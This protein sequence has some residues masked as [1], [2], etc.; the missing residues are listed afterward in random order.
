MKGRQVILLNPAGL[1]AELLL[2]EIHKRSDLVA[3]GFFTLDWRH[4]DFVRNRLPLPATMAEIVLQLEGTE[5]E[6]VCALKLRATKQKWNIAAVIPWDDCSVR[7]G[8]RISDAFHLPWIS[9]EVAERF[10]NKYLLKRYLRDHT[11]LRLN[12]FENCRDAQQALE[13]QRTL[14]TWPVILKPVDAGG[15]WNVWK[16]S[17]E[18]EITRF[19]NRI[20]SDFND[21][22]K[23]PNREVL[24]EEHV[25][26]PE[27]CINGL[28][29][30]SGQVLVTDIFDYDQRTLHGGSNVHYHHDYIDPRSSHARPLVEYATAVI[31]AGGLRNSPF[32]LE[33]RQGAEGPVLMEVATRFAGHMAALVHEAIVPDL[34][35]QALKGYL[36]EL[37]LSQPVQTVSS[38][39]EIFA[40]VVEGIAE[41]EGILEA[42]EGLHEVERL[43]SFRGFSKAPSLGSRVSKT[44]NQDGRPYVGFLAHPDHARLQ[45]DKRK[46][47]QLLRLTIRK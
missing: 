26:G 39:T 47:R 35:A 46:M 22:D 17:T 2:R 18:E 37:R 28:T 27:F 45:E 15:A 4:A 20:L 30:A 31:R 42:V 1:Y 25:D 10:K 44:I 3:V 19:T 7:L 33:L 5:E 41:E 36:G 16:A 12:R 29:D 32:H 9:A 23:T 6:Q 38:Q 21:F 11:A 24:V 40:T 14:G 13:F 43:P 8:G 34:M